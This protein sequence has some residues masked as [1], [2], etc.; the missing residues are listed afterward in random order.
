MSLTAGI[1]R[2]DGFYTED[3]AAALTAEEHF[4]AGVALEYAK[5]YS[6]AVAEFSRAIQLDSN[7]PK[8]WALRGH[9]RLALPG[10]GLAAIED[11][12]HAVELSPENW[13]F[14]KV[15]IRVLETL[16]R[17]QEADKEMQHAMSRFGNS[18]QARMLRGQMRLD[19]NDWAAAV[20]DFKK[21]CELNP[22]DSEA[23][24]MLARA[25]EAIRRSQVRLDWK[26]LNPNATAWEKKVAKRLVSGIRGV[27]GC[28]LTGVRMRCHRG[29]TIEIDHLIVCEKGIFVVE[30][31][32]YTGQIKG[33]LNG[34]WSALDE[35][36]QTRVCAQRGA[37]PV[38][39]TYEQI[40]STVRRM[41]EIDGEKHEKVRGVVVFPNEANIALN[42]VPTNRLESNSVAVFHIDP[43]IATLQA[44]PN[45]RQ[46]LSSDGTR[47]R[48]F[49]DRLSQ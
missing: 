41:E 8:F 22:S 29:G 12:R 35:T 9:A 49:I 11:S 4:R 37:N 3:S 44:L 7:Q 27:E 38:Q 48:A 1:T 10:Q 25:E 24:A 32:N 20:K 13:T 40:Y 23:P 14:R 34:A 6:E 26:L 39:Q 45:T 33:G 5:R 36:K 16:G 21:A 47:R 19:R 2:P 18:F 31:K 43:L 46:G 42:D 28:I 17:L 30:C 15:L